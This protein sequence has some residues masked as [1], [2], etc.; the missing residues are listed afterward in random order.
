MILMNPF[1]GQR[2]TADLENGDLR[3]LWTQWGK[4]KWDE[5]SV[6]LIYIYTTVFKID[7]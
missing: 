2:Q 7:S 1:A 6:A 5:L 3:D 4:K